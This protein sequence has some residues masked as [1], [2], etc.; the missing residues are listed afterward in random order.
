MALA[1]K[2]WHVYSGCLTDKG[3]KALSG[4]GLTT[5]RP[6]LLDVTNAQRIEEVVAQIDHEHPEG[7]YAVINNAGELARD[8]EGGCRWWWCLNCSGRYVVRNKVSER[9]GPY[10]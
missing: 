9:V 10:S 4:Y 7:L 8:R 1:Q 6:L 5:L 2:G 3:V